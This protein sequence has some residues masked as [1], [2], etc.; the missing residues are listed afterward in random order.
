VATILAF[1]Q[2]R[3]LKRA[4]SLLLEDGVCRFFPDGSPRTLRQ[5][6]CMGA[7]SIDPAAALGD[8]VQPRQSQDSPSPAAGAL[9]GGLRFI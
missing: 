5:E 6:A 9:W 7:R 1:P 4:E 8:P 3:A 2:R